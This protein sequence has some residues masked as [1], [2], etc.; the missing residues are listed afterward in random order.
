MLH[1]FPEHLYHLNQTI[2]FV[3][4]ESL[5]VEVKSSSSPHLASLALTLPRH[6]ARHHDDFAVRDGSPSLPW[7]RGGDASLSLVVCRTHSVR[8]VHRL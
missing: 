3:L 5:S 2:H 4:F 1:Q 7:R 8:L 6:D